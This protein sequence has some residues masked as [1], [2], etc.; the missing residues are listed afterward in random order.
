MKLK[1]VYAGLDGDFKVDASA[2]E[3]FV[4]KNTVAIVGTAGTAELGVVDPIEELAY[5]ALLMF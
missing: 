4:S 5:V 1:L 3:K 2:V